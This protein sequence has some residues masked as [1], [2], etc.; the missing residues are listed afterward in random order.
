MKQEVKDP[1]CPT[2]GGLI[3]AAMDPFGGF[4]LACKNGHE[5]VPQITVT[6]AI[7]DPNANSTIT[8]EI[9]SS[10]IKRIPDYQPPAGGNLTQ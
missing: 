8:V 9:R 1:R 6:T 3:Y 7:V 4:T 5:C 2:C 10:E